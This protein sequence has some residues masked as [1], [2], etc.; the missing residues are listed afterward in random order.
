[1]HDLVFRGARVADGV[2]NPLVQAFLQ[3]LKLPSS[4]FARSE[5]LGFLECPEIRYCFGIR[6]DM[7]DEIMRLVE[8]ARVR[9]GINARH[10]E[11]LGLPAMHENTW[12]QAWEHGYALIQ[13][14]RPNRFLPFRV[15]LFWI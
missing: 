8:A 5:I 11:E 3:L 14:I 13:T 2:G 15:R 7:T 1:M 10:R 4:R 12:Q 6:P 9:W